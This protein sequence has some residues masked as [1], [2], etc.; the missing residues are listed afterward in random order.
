MGVRLRGLSCFCS[1][2]ICSGSGSYKQPGPHRPVNVTHD[3]TTQSWTERALALTDAG[4][5]LH[6][7]KLASSSLCE[8]RGG[9]CPKPRMSSAVESSLVSSWIWWHLAGPGGAWWGLEG[10]GG[11]WRRLEGPGGAWRGLE[12]PGGAWRGLEGPGGAW[13]GLEGPGGAW[14]GLEGPGGAWRG[15][16]GPGG[17]WRGLEGPGGAWRGLEGPGGAW[18]DLVDLVGPGG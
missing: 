4:C 6:R 11:A 12:G 17:A 16:V 5:V 2:T 9:L 18:W 1:G 7:H 10:P 13:R 8:A 14:R 3:M 15:L